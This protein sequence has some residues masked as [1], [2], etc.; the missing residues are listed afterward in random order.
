[1]INKYNKPGENVRKAMA[2]YSF[3]DMT[4]KKIK[5]ELNNIIY[6]GFVLD[7]KYQPKCRCIDIRTKLKV[8]TGIYLSPKID[9]IESNT[10]MIYFNGK[11][12]KIALMVSVL[13]DKIRQPD[14]NYWVLRDEEIEINKIIFKEIHLDIKFDFKN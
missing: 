9:F 4:P 7:N 12:Y 1:M 11:A 5:R 10:G 3:N 13:S 14:S 2:Y 8:G 6:N